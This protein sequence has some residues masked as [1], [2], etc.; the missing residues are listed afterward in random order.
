[1][2]DHA[3]WYVADREA[4]DEAALDRLSAAFEDRIY[5]ND[6]AVFGSEWTPGVDNDPRI[7][8]LFAPLRGAGGSFSAADEYT[9]AVNPYS[10]EREMMYISTGAGWGDLEGTLAHEFQ[11][12]IHWHEHANQDIWLN[13]GASVLAADLNGYGVLGVDVSFMRDPN[14]QLNAWQASPGQARP[15][16]GAAFLFLDYL[17]AHYGGERIIRAAIDSP[18]PSTDA[19]D[20][21]LGALGYTDRFKDVV[22]KWALA[23]LLDEEPGADGQYT[24]PKREVQVSPEMTMDTFP[25]GYSGQ[26]SQFGATYIELQAPTDGTQALHVDF[27]GRPE[28]S[29]IPAPAH[30]GSAI[31]Y[32]NRG[33]L[34]DSTMTRK[35]NLSDLSK[36]TLDCYLWYDIEPDFDYAYVEASTDGGATWATLEGKYTSKAN[37]NGTNY[38]NA[39]TGKSAEQAGADGGGWVHETYD[40]TPYAGKEV[41]VRFEYITD[42]GYNVQGLAVDDISV[43][44]LGYYDYDDTDSG[45]QTDGFVRVENVLPQEWYLAAVRFGNGTVDIKPV[46]VSPSGEA[47]FDIDGLGAGGPYNKATLVIMGMTPHNIQHPT[48]ELSVRPGK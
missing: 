37:P 1:V 15:N 18:H 22:E 24:Y 13:E 9:R 21:A 12:M 19:I 43:P 16:Y 48:Y 8:V 26:A 36:A 2:T 44:E 17:M 28:T 31:W 29:V 34:A 47:N 20:Y 10:N 39:Y 14:V 40:L 6:R 41:L 4:V 3:Y 45:W 27:A 5:P 33:D 38:G 25:N 11:H 46:E 35:F 7:T 23:N 32:S 42:D 30:T